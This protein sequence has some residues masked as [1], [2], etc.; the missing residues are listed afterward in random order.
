MTKL[1]DQ[2]VIADAQ[3][4][5]ETETQI[6]VTIDGVELIVPN[7]PDKRHYAEIMPQVASGDLTIADAP[8]LETD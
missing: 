8:V 4:K 5:D 3:Y 1:E 6:I 2:S 7:D